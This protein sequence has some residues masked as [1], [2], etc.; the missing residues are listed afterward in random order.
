MKGPILKNLKGPVVE[1]SGLDMQ[2]FSCSQI[3]AT[4]YARIISTAHRS[5]LLMG[6]QATSSDVSLG[7]LSL[8]RMAPVRGANVTP[9]LSYLVGQKGHTLVHTQWLTIEKL[10]H[11]FTPLVEEEET[12][13]TLNREELGNQERL[14]NHKHLSLSEY[15]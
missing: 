8:S 13:P 3:H 2:A 4:F 12:L 6:K 15:F 1:F 11:N 10:K 5:P 9:D 7:Q 14:T